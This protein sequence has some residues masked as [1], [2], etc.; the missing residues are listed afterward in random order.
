MDLI[1]QICPIGLELQR[2]LAGLQFHPCNRIYLLT[3]RIEAKDY[4]NVKDREL[5]DKLVE[6]SE[7]FTQKIKKEI[8]LPT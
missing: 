4:K 1:I 2:I 3:S 6:L 7:V 8:P 5:D